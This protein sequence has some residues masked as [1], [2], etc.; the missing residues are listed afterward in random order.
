[1]AL[2]TPTTAASSGWAT[3]SSTTA[4][5]APGKLAVT[6]TWGGTMSGNCDRGMRCNA[7]KPASVIS[8]ARTMASL[9]RSTKTAEI[10]RSVPHGRLR[11]HRAWIDDQ[12]W[13]GA[14]DALGDDRLAFLQTGGDHGGG[15]SRLAKGDAADLGFVV[16]TD[17][18]NVVAL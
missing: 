12:A 17:D 13:T 10:I 18:V 6:V 5:D 11:T 15:W 9:G 14:L 1:M 7:S 3:V 16:R 8:T 4:A 2:S